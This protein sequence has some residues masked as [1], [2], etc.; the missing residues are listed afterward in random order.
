MSRFVCGLEKE[1]ERFNEMAY[2]AESAAPV[3]MERYAPDKVASRGNV[4]LITNTEKN[5]SRIIFTPGVLAFVMFIKNKIADD[6]AAAEATSAFID[7]FT[8][9][10]K[11]A[12]RDG[13]DLL[14]CGKK[15]MGMSVIFNG[16]MAMVRF[17]M[18]L[19]AEAVNA[20]FSERD[21][22]GYKYKGVT[23]VCDETSIGEG[24]ARAMVYEFANYLMKW[25]QKNASE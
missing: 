5:G 2:I 3:V 15:A 9:G 19:R 18:T 14:I 6:K 25:R 21:F 4:Y 1:E 24:D 23:G 7:Y 20:F 13:N 16:D 10:I 12:Y 11:G 17:V 8:S 22:D